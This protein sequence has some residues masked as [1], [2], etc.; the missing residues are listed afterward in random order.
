MSYTYSI[1]ISKLKE[2]K[3]HLSQ[4]NKINTLIY[5]SYYKLMRKISKCH[6]VTKDNKYLHV[7][8][9]QYKGYKRNI[10]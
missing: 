5:K 2:N 1:K 7:I 6:K 10:G 8:L 3:L 9:L 4:Y